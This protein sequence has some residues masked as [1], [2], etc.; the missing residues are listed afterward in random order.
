[1]NR[2]TTFMVLTILT[3][4]TLLV[5]WLRYDFGA[6]IA[7]YALLSLFGVLMF[8]G[9]AILFISLM[10]GVLFTQ[11][12]VAAK[13]ARVDAERYRL[14]REAMKGDN[15]AAAIE[16]RRQPAQLPASDV[17]TIDAPPPRRMLTARDADEVAYE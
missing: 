10:R 16:A 5:V 3:F 11:Q 7:A 1:M 14:M 8:A 12:E 9:G 13:D 15:R 2:N 4:L 6:D 17:W